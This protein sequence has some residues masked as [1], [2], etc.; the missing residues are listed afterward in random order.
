MNYWILYYYY[1]LTVSNPLVQYLK[2]VG[3]IWQKLGQY[4][5]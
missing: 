3:L 5:H 1:C 2:K 4:G